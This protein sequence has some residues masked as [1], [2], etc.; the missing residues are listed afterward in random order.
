MHDRA[1][2]GSEHSRNSLP[3]MKHV[4]LKPKHQH[5]RSRLHPL[6]GLTAWQALVEVAR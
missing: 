6:V 4:A 5:G 2:I 1:I 3:S